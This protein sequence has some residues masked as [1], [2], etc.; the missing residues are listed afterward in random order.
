MRA[1]RRQT[2]TF[3]FEVSADAGEVATM[4]CV[5]P[6]DCAHPVVCVCMCACVVCVVCVQPIG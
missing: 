4:V 3:H 2:K 5:Q 1:G 6:S